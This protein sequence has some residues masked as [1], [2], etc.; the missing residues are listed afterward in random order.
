MQ[1]ETIQT[2]NRALLEWLV[3][4][5]LFTWAQIETV[6]HAQIVLALE[7]V[8]PYAGQ[9][10]FDSTAQFKVYRGLDFLS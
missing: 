4:R 8:L 6:A 10:Q 1:A 2:S 5:K 3:N 9:F 7:Q